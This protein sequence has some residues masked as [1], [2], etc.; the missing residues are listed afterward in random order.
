MASLGQ[1]FDMRSDLFAHIQTFSF[2]NLDHMQTG[3]LLIRLG[4]NVEIGC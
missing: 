3:Q 2:A 1:T 4:S